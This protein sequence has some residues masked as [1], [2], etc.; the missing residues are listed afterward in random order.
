MKGPS[1][2]HNKC[3]QLGD[4]KQGLNKDSINVLVIRFESII[5]WNKQVVQAICKARKSLHA[6]KHPFCRERRKK[7]RHDLVNLKCLALYIKTDES[8]RKGNRS[9]IINIVLLSCD[10]ICDLHD[11]LNISLRVNYVYSNRNL[12]SIFMTR[13]KIPY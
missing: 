6:I 2:D 10:W 8:T 9:R 7:R 11:A 12:H 3:Q 4:K 1:N 5:Q 13:D